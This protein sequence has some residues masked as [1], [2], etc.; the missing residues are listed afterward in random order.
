MK[1]KKRR[2]GTIPSP[3]SG[4]VLD[5]FT[6]AQ[7][8]EWERGGDLLQGL[9]DKVYFEL[10]AHRV[11]KYDDLCDALRGSSTISIDVGGWSRVTD[12]RWSLSPLSNAGSIKGIGGRFNIGETLD[13][14][15]GQAFSALYIA[16]RIGSYGADTAFAVSLRRGLVAQI[17]GPDGVKLKS[18]RTRATS[19]SCRSCRR[20]LAVARRRSNIAIEMS[21]GCY[22]GRPH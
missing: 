7:L 15:R 10:E 6:E 8:E 21:C 19:K 22:A 1:N 4:I 11:A 2:P 3:A 13:R 16:F 18:A 20:S 14:A 17:G 12:W 5:A 9:A